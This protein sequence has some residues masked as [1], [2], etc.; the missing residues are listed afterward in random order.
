[1]ANKGESNQLHAEADLHELD[2]ALALAIQKVR[3]K[4]ASELCRYLPSEKGPGHMHHFSIDKLKKEDP[5]RLLQMV[6]K[7]IVQT[8]EPTKIAPKQRAARGSRK[9]QNQFTFSE[10]EVER[11]RQY[12]KIAGDEDMARRL[13]PQGDPASM[14]RELLSSIRQNRV[15]PDLWN[16]YVDWITSIHAAQM[17]SRNNTE[18]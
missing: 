12:A 4:K 14:K 17:R 13:R 2:R 15:E 8:E 1:M 16:A 9:R 7:Y 6:Q 5:T 3:G 18:V 11:I 10:Q